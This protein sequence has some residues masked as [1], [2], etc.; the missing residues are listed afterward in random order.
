MKYYTW[1]MK[2]EVNPD[3]GTEEGLE[4]TS[5]SD[6]NAV[7]FVVSFRDKDVLDKTSTAYG[8]STTSIDVSE[9]ADY[10][11]TE[12]TAVQALAAAQAVD[13]EATM[14]D[15]GLIIFPFVAPVV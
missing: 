2:W 14:D 6:E 10:L 11:M 4:P 12:I 3:T 15:D 8:V 7:S 9:W 13:E 1:K 5:F